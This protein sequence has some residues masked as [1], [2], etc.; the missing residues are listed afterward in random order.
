MKFRIGQKIVC[1][2]EPWTPIEAPWRSYPKYGEVYTMRG[3]RPD[4]DDL[5]S[6]LLVEIVNDIGIDGLEAGFWEGRF[7]PVVTRESD[8]S[9][10]KALLKPKLEPVE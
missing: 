6:L 5:I 2:K 4:G 3:Y 10:F 7:R 9:C 8:I 1:I